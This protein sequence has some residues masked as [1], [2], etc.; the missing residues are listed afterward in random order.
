MAEP[1]KV[2]EVLASGAIGGGASHVESL[3]RTVDPERFTLKVATTP[4]LLQTLSQA[5]G[6]VLGLGA[7]LLQN[8]GTLAGAMRDVQLVHAHGTLAALMAAPGAGFH[9]VPLVYTVHGWSFHPRRF[10]AAAVM[11]EGGLARRCRQVV[12]VSQDDWFQGLDCGVLQGASSRVIPNGI[13]LERFHP[14]P[15][16]RVRLRDSY[17]IAPN[18]PVIG[19]CGRLTHQKAPELFVLAAHTIL[20]R[21]PDASFLMLGDGSERPRL[22]GLAQALGLASHFH[23]L[24]EQHDVP[25]WLAALDCF[26]LPSRWEGL[27]IVLL[28]AM[29]AG[30]PV[31]ATA[32]NGSREL[33]RHGETGLLVPPDHLAELIVAIFSILADPERARGYAQAAQARVKRSYSLAQMVEALQALYLEVTSTHARCLA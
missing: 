30:V 27:P 33:I 29:A 5:G 8:V 3:A 28:E 24:G 26:V 19:F 4:P 31:V 10:R 1:I 12:C 13:D 23:F 9:R 25:A 11:L 18:A 2:L 17:G 14:D 21:C 7:G 32:V 20:S 16:A 22:E 15:A 6:P